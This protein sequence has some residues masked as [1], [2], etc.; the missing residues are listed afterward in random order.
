MGYIHP[1][2]N[3]QY[4][5]YANRLLPYHLDRLSLTKIQRG[6]MRTKQFDHEK[7]QL[8]VKLGKSKSYQ[9]IGKDNIEKGVYVDVL[10]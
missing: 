7:N 9:H 1:V 2:P 8:S 3:H 6:E 4:T 10:V 5:Q